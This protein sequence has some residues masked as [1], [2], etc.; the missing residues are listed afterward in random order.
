MLRPLQ[1]RLIIKPDAPAIESAGGILF[2]QTHGKPPA[3]TG[4]VISVGKGPAT[5]HRVRQATIAHC[6]QLLN[7]VAEQVPAATLRSE[8]EDELARYAVEDVTFSEVSSGDYVCFAYTAGH[9]MQVDGESFI[10]IEEG[11]VQAVWQ[12][13]QV[14]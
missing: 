5:A 2:P 13:E 1:N 12:K 11:D 4:T 7:Q 14:A 9:N 8:L 3:M 10:V 6:I